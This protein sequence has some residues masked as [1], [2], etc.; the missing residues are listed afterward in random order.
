MSPSP[1]DDKFLPYGVDKT[2]V[3]T[4]EDDTS[5]KPIHKANILYDLS[6]ALCVAFASI[7]GAVT[8]NSQ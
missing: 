8:V 1:G 5:Y 2:V 3:C 6:T 7:F 4:V